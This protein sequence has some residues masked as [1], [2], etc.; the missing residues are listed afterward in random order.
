MSSVAKA[1]VP[2]EDLGGEDVKHKPVSRTAMVHTVFQALDEKKC[3]HEWLE[4]ASNM[5]RKVIHKGIP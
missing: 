4:Q 2:Y 5:R 3:G 1:A